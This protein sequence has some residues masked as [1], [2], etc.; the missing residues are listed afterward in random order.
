MCQCSEASEN[1]FAR[2]LAR[3]LLELARVGGSF[4]VEDHFDSLVSSTVRLSDKKKTTN[5]LKT[6]TAGL[7]CCMW[8]N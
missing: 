1:E 8:R 3:H 4:H 7:K 5:K 2:F 6:I